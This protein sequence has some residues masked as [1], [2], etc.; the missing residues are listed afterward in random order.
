MKTIIFKI[1]TIFLL[2]TLMGGCKKESPVSPPGVAIYKTRN[3]YF[4]HV[5]TSHKNEKVIEKPSLHKKVDFDENGNI[6][7]LFREKLIDGYVLAGDDPINTAFLRYSIREYYDME[8]QGNLPS[9]DEIQAN[10]I[11]YDPFVEY[12]SDPNSPGLGGFELKDTARINEIIRN[13]E[14]MKYFKKLK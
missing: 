3:D 10:V 6:H 7:Y 4:N 12:Y 5:R 14:I 13:G 9:I 1:C 11:D 2:F 8:N